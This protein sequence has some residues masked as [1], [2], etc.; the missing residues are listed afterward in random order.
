MKK[1]RK[2]KF[3]LPF[4]NERDIFQWGPVP[5]IFFYLSV[6][7]E[8]HFKHFRQQYGENWSET[9]W[10]FKN[11]RM[12]WLNNSQ[13]VEKA[14][15]RVFVRYLLP[16]NQQNKIYA[17][18]QGHVKSLSGLYAKISSV[19][20]PQVPNSLLLKL[21]NYFHSL[22]IK[23]WVDGSVPE[24]ANYGSVS[25]LDKKL[26]VYM[27]DGVLRASAL[28]TLTAPTK[29]SFYQE[30]EIDL[31]KTKD[32]DKH[33][34]QYFWLKN[35]YAGTQ[36]LPVSFF[37][38]RK[39]LLKS[40]L[41]KEIIQKLKQTRQKKNIVKKQYKLPKEI[42]SIAEA[43]SSGIAW[44]DERKKYIFIALHYLDILAKEIAARIGHKFSDF[45][46]LWYFEIA[47]VIKGKNLRK[48]INNRKKGFGVQFFHTCKQLSP[49]QT[50]FVWKAYETKHERKEQIEIKGIIASK[51]NG[52]KINGKVRILLSPSKS[53]SFKK[54]EI[55]VAPMTS[56]EYIFAMRKA[57]ALLTDTGGLTSHAA[58]VS[59]E[60]G[61]PCLV[62]TKLATKVFK[63]GDLVEVDPNTGVAKKIQ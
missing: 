51:G 33:Q 32:L 41:E 37:K 40:N 50:A 19:N 42:M 46:N 20:L 35:S 27:P 24:L 12:L 18:W 56:P 2:S 62:G 9:F 4:S 38:Q 43:I 22:Y 1:I 63:N 13:D 48:E 52:K 31:S 44:Q 47:D 45:N 17:Q 60:L 53:Q 39:N 26:S 30:E 11:G 58:I 55:L 15:R 3:P 36:I 10:L 28:E 23:F 21:W 59:R 8:V 6:F 57:C 61:I 54:G 5:G 25:Y 49:S 7:T 34:Q 29:L 14:G 16:R